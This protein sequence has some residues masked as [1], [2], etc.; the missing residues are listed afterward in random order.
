[1]KPLRTKPNR[2]FHFIVENDSIWYPRSNPSKRQRRQKK[3]MKSFWWWHLLLMKYDCKMPNGRMNFVR[4]TVAHYHN[5]FALYMLDP[6]NKFSKQCH[7]KSNILFMYMVQC[8]LEW[9]ISINM[10]YTWSSFS[11]IQVLCVIR[12]SRE[13]YYGWIGRN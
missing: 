7:N 1:M 6:V 8:I 11:F 3:K 13:F 2:T 4:H 12:K 5:N 9:G 10:L